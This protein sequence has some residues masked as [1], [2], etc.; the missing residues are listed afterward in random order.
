MEAANFVLMTYSLSDFH[1]RV[2]HFVRS[3]VSV[4]LKSVRNAV[5]WNGSRRSLIDLLV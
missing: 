4:A 2:K 3:R 5:E 1:C